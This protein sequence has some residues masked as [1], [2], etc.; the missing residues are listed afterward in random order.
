MVANDE[1]GDAALGVPPDPGFEGFPAGRRRRRAAST[2]FTSP[3]PHAVGHAMAGGAGVEYYFGYSLP[4]N[5][6]A[7][8]NWR[9]RERSWDSRGRARL[10]PRRAHPLPGDGPRTAWSA[11]RRGQPPLLPSRSAG[12][13]YLVYLPKGGSADLDLSGATGRFTVEWLDPRKGGPLQ[14]GSV[15]DVAGGSPVSLGAPP[16]D[17]RRRLAGGRAPTKVTHRPRRRPREGDRPPGHQA[18]E[19]LCHRARRREGARLGLANGRVTGEHSPG[20]DTRRSTSQPRTPC[21]S[22]I[23]PTVSKTTPRS[24]LLLRMYRTSLHTPLTPPH[25]P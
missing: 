6:L 24:L 8:E 14:N 4:Q 12:E 10:L 13:V 11:I 1:Q 21:T 17:P 2:T 19:H 9:S 25:N 22:Y 23:R 3:P 7:C 5:D 15:R 20:R 18:R 16:A